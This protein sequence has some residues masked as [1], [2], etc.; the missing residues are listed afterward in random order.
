MPMLHLLGDNHRLPLFDM[1]KSFIWI[2][3]AKKHINEFDIGYIINPSLHVNKAFRDQV[4]N[5]S[6]LHLVNSHNH[7]LKPHFQKI[8]QVF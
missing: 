8:I 6:I 1:S 5:V 3:E 4:E 7:L 2:N